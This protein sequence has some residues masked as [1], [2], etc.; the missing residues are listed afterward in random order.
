MKKIVSLLIFCAMLV[1]LV[2]FTVGAAGSILWTDDFDSG[3][4]N[5]AD[6]YPGAFTCEQGGPTKSPHVEDWAGWHVLQSMY[7]N[8]NGSNRTFGANVCFKVDGWAMDDGGNDAADHKL[9]LWWAD[10]FDAT[11]DA[12]RIVYLYLVNYETR[13]ASLLAS[14]EGDGEN[15]YETGVYSSGTVVAEWTIPDDQA[16]EMDLSEPS[17]ISLGMRINGATIDC[18]FNDIKAISFNAPRMGGEKSPILLVND[19]CYAGFDNFVVATADYDL[20]NEGDAMNAPAANNGAANDAPAQTE[21]VVETETRLV[22][23]TDGNTVV[24]VVTNEVVRPAANTGAATTG[25]T[26]ART[27]DAAIIVIAVM[28]VALGAAITVAKVRVGK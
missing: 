6:W 17:V 21:K 1:S 3:S 27:G 23:D 22:T 16:L 9:G 13:K 26:A 28:I 14:G 19:G 12:G 18:Y 7:G 20:F 11:G 24:E 2:P 15:F 8:E 25:G 5:E 4:I 10:Y